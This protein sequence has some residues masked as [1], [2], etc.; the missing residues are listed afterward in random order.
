M[1]FWPTMGRF[2][3]RDLLVVVLFLCRTIVCDSQCPKFAEKPLETRVQDAT[4]VFR[5]V[6]VQT[7]YQ[8]KTLDLALVSIYRGGVELAS[9][10]QYAGSPYN[11]T[12][13]WA[14]NE[15]DLFYGNE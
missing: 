15:I 14:T 12:D 3:N 7:H 9:I 8:R 4:I 2:T 6:V 10:S 13:R 1:G 11:T 5:A